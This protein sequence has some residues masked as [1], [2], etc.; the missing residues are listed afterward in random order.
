MTGPDRFAVEGG[1]D[2]KAAGTATPD[3]TIS[4][5]PTDILRWAWNRES[6]GEPS[7]VRVEGNLKALAEFR[8]C[9]VAATQ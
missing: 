7:A 4:G 1:P 8:A 2:E 9:V 6:P 5:S 3:V